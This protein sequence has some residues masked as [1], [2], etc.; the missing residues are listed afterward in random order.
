M[1]RRTLNMIESSLPPED[2]NMPW[3]DIDENSGRIKCIHT[4]NKSKGEWEPYLAD[5]EYMSEDTPQ[6]PE[7]GILDSSL[8]AGKAIAVMQTGDVST[9][10]SAINLG[11][12][13]KDLPMT[14]LGIAISNSDFYW[15]WST[16]QTDLKLTKELN[17]SKRYPAEFEEYELPEGA[18]S[19]WDVFEEIHLHV[20]TAKINAMRANEKVND[21]HWVG[22]F[23]PKNPAWYNSPGWMFLPEDVV[24]FK[25]VLKK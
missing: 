8:Y 7:D 19:V 9:T 17:D 16:G 3:V 21:I 20:D 15:R 10:A 18:S 4:F 6:I 24:S 1:K 25:F 14:G 13:V 23:N 5:V 22:F 12:F 2:V 11:F